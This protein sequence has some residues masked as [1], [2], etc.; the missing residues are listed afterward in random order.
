[1]ITKVEQDKLDVT[2][3]LDDYGI[4]YSIVG[5]N[6]MFCCP[7]HG[8]TNPSCGMNVETGLWGCFACEAKG[9][10]VS[11]V[12]QYDDV[13]MSIAEERIK[14]KFINHNVDPSSI[15]S[16]VE[17]ILAKKKEDKKPNNIVI[18]EWTLGQY[19]KNYDYMYSRG[20]TKE[21]LDHFKVVYNETNKYQGFPVYNAEGG[22]VGIS[23]RN[24]LNEE[25]RYL[26]L[27]RFQKA[28]VVFNL[29]QIDINEPVIVVEGEINCMAMYQKGYHNTIAVLGASVA[30]D[31]IEIL[32]NSEI[33][34]LIIFFDTDPAGE[35]GTNKL[36]SELWKYMKIK[37]V[38]DHE[39]DPA[40]ME[41]TYI[42]TLVNSAKYFYT[43]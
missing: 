5:Q 9:N 41:K 11:F 8:E 39:G 15:E 13:P 27:I 3:V 23:G 24:T 16:I 28:Q 2:E 21:T 34:E 25:P 29:H 36:I 33:K 10:I 42:D 31:Q 4:N 19:T 22:L 38:E 14:R 37:V 26:P 30:H 20:F 32:K 6:A 18:P 35:K 17:R 7:F 1:M 12:S 40:D 43:V